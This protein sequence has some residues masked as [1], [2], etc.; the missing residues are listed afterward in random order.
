MEEG[1]PHPH[2]SATRKTSSTDTQNEVVDVKNLRKIKYEEIFQ[3]TPSS[4]HGNVTNLK[5][6]KKQRQYC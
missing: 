5:H 1:H 3:E 4:S 2:W 6:L